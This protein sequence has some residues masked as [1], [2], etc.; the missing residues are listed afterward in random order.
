[1]A[2]YVSWNQGHRHGRHGASMH[3]HPFG[4]FL[5]IAFGFMVLS[6]LFKSGLI[7]F[8]MLFFGLMMVKGAAKM[9]GAMCGKTHHDDTDD[10]IETYLKRKNDDLYDESDKRKNDDDIAYF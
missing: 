8:V 3:G 5:G 10:D 4:M 9:G 2:R 7:F 1:M 6:F